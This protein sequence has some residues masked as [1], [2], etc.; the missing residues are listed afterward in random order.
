[1]KTHIQFVLI[2]AAQSNVPRM[3]KSDQNK[4]LL[5]DRNV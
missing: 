5:I 2:N 1:M 3:T 4:S